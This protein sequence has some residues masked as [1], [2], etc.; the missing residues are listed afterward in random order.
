MFIDMP[1]G[2]TL[3][4]N[5]QHIRPFVESGNEHVGDNQSPGKRLDRLDL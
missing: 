3:K 1:N 2:N 4:R 5:R